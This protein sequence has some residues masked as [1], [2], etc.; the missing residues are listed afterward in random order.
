MRLVPA[1]I[2]KKLHFRVCRLET[3]PRDYVKPLFLRQIEMFASL[4][5]MARKCHRQADS[6]ILF[7]AMSSSGGGLP[8]RLGLARVQG[9]RYFGSLFGSKKNNIQFVEMVK[10]TV[11]RAW[12]STASS[13]R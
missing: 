4:T 6:S 9:A 11:I 1:I 13:P 5:G 8:G 7:S 2:R 12:V 3:L 10:L